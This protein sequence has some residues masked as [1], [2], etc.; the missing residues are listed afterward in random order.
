MKGTNLYKI[1][2]NGSCEY[3]K[4]PQAALEPLAKKILETILQ[5]LNETQAELGHGRDTKQ[6]Q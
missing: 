6:Q 3:S 5:H 4:I 1:Y 2:V